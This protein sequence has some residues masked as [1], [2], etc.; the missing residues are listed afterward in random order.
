MSEPTTCHYCGRLIQRCP[1]PRPCSGQCSSGHGWK[2]IP[3]GR[4]GCDKRPRG[5][6]H[7]SGPYAMPPEARP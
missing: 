6:R 7:P 4:H 5:W 1:E 2:H 3:E